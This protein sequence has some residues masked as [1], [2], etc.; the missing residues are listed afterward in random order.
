[1][2]SSTVSPKKSVQSYDYLDRIV[3]ILRKYALIV[4]LIILIIVAAFIEP[5]FIS[6]QNIRNV[7]NQ[8]SVIGILACGMTFVIITGCIDLSVGS[9]ISI[10]GIVVIKMVKR[11]GDFPGI[12]MALMLGALFGFLIGLVMARINGR[13]GESFMVTYGAQTALAG[14]AMIVSGGLFL[15]SD[16]FGF[17][18]R[19]GK[20]ANPIVI[21]L[22]LILICQVFIKRTTFGRNIYFLGANPE[23]AKLSGINIGRYRVLIFTLSGAI[24][25]LAG[26]VLPSRVAAAN[27]TA[28]VGY[29]L[30]AIAAV[31]VG[32][33][34]MSGG[35]GTF[36]NTLM[37]VIVI[38]VLGNALNIMN[39]TSYP[40][41]IIKGIVI[42]AAVSLDMWNRSIS[43]GKE[44]LKN[45]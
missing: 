5:R 29:E 23:A 26:I 36:L 33:I 44:I 28:G 10:T 21:F 4:A 43:E 37:G 2:K 19:I 40:Q 18:S 7:L 31:V 8:V 27:P 12:I 13:L 32:G 17:F 9:V 24:A 1:M 41:M 14:L 45:A 42:A 20:G 25:A 22:A 16:T 11:F 34:S 30:D 15:M 35:S 39:V 6:F 38:G 3:G